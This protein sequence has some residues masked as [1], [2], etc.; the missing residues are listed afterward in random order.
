[1]V[2]VKLEGVNGAAMPKNSE[3][4]YDRFT[5][6]YPIVDLF[7]KPQK[8]K[9]FG[10]INS[11]PHGQLLEIGVGNG[12]HFEYY[13]NHEITGVDNSG[14]M[15][16][17]AGKHLKDNIQL[18]QMN[19]ETLGFPEAAFD[20]VVLSHVIAVVADPEKLLKEV[21]RVLKPGGKIFI[22]NHFTPDNCLKYLDKAFGRISP[23]FYFKSVFHISALRELEKFKLLKEFNAGMFSYFKILIYEKSL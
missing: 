14:S 22:L 21:N 2:S 16:V 17:R 19:G 9:F 12:A 5:L 3:K 20:Y 10:K 15:L 4:F 18:H 1:M 23:L 11:Y 6:L 8:R 7:L 13:R